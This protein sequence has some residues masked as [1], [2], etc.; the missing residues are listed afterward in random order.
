[1]IRCRAMDCFKVLDYNC[2]ISWGILIN[3]ILPIVSK[4]C[5][6]VYKGHETEQTTPSYLS[7]HFNSQAVAPVNWELHAGMQTPKPLSILTLTVH[8]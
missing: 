3:G 5:G 8:A 4:R 2:M 7:L 1:M 6:P